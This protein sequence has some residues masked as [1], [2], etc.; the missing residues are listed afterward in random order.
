MA[1]RPGLT[2][3]NLLPQDEFEKSIIGKIL[4]WALSAGKSIVV[5]T[6]FVVILAFLSR[7]K[8]DRDLNDLNEVIDQ[9]TYI[10]EGFGETEKKMRDLQALSAVVEEAEGSS[11]GFG[12]WWQRLVAVTPLDT[13]YQTVDLS[14]EQVS[15][16][17]VSGSEVGFAGLIKKVKQLEGV[18]EVSIGD[19]EFNQQQG[20][21]SFNLVARLAREKL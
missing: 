2:R 4:R 15:L 19:V 13:R 6:E 8:L 9:K 3:I 16:K 11:V 10:V 14:R 5:I 18:S 12:E 7:F 17:G 1:A 21:V 20:G